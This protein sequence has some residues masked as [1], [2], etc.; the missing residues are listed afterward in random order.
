M[1]CPGVICQ[2]QLNILQYLA[3]HLGRDLGVGGALGE[4]LPDGHKGED[5]LAVDEEE[6]PSVN[7]CLV[8][9]H[10]LVTIVTILVAAHL[11]IAK[12][13]LSSII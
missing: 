12:I 4:L 11:N 8:L 3:D 7:P 6:L 5:R 13:E 1:L 2:I 9:Q 10:K